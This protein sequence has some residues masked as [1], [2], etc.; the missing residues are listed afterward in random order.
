M[1]DLIIIQPS[2]TQVTVTED[3]NEVVVSSV[4]VQGAKGDTGATGAAGATGA[5]GSSG[6]IA[7]TAPI[8]NSGTST[9]A[10]IGIS[11]ANIASKYAAPSYLSY[12]SGYYYEPNTGATITT[13][14]PAK[15]R[16]ILTPFF[17]SQN[18]T[19]DRIGM[20]CTVAIASTV[21]RLGIYT[22]DSNGLPS[23]LLLDAGTVDTSSTGLKE[24]TI[25]QAL[26]A[27]LYY[28]ATANQGSTGNPSVRALNTISGNYAPIGAASMG[29]TQYEGVYFQASVGGA[30]PSTPTVVSSNINPARVQ[31]RVA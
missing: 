26:S 25:S 30:L 5:T 28:L 3:V 24:I 14:S 23:T 13:T 2:I 6:V 4:G 9:S 19:L 20:E 22:S 17:V 31:V 29:T 8:T 15:N 21:Y 12:R 11:L 7:V 18:V 1:S 16:L 10:N 27:G